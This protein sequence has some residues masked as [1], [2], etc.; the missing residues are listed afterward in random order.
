M[1]QGKN[2]SPNEED[3]RPEENPI[4]AGAEAQNL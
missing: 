1:D 2:A 4:L 3:I